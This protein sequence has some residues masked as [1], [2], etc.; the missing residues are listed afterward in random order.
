MILI[1]ESWRALSPTSV[2]TVD[3]K[4]VEFQVD[5]TDCGHYFGH[6][7]LTSSTI[8]PRGQVE[9]GEGIF[10]K[11]VAASSTLQLVWCR[12]GH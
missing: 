3:V 8:V 2:V 1:F 9:T 5:L 4:V 7:V 11:A 6:P 12:S 10:L